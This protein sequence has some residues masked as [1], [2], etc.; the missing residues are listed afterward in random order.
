MRFSVGVAGGRRVAVQD[1]GPADG[2]AV[3]LMHGTPGSRLGPRPGPAALHSLGV[4][5]ICYDRPGFGDSDRLPGR[6]VAHA[7]EDTAAVAEFLGV[8]AFAVVGRSGGGPHALACAALLPDRVSAVAALVSLAPRD[9]P[10]LDWYQG[11]G[12]GNTAEFR[13]AENGSAALGSYL[14]PF[15]VKIR[16]N[17]EELIPHAEPELPKTASSSTSGTTGRAGPAQASRATQGT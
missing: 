13:A 11:M 1:W 17:P 12:A 14:A 8:G 7:A 15:A 16:S 3:F 5:L 10:D 2:A 6:A 4:R 9:V